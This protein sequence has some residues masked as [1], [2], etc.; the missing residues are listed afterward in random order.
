MKGTY[1]MN[2][3]RVKKKDAKMIYIIVKGECLVERTLTF[4]VSSPY[5]KSQSISKNVTTVR[6]AVV[7]NALLL[8]NLFL[9]NCD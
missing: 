6:L 4:E 1:L 3:G 9:M 7:G 5:N 2:E 8:L